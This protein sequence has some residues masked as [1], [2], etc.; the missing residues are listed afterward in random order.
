MVD[1]YC[2]LE[3]ALQ[4]QMA[5]NDRFECELWYFQDLAPPLS[6]FILR[7][8]ERLQERYDNALKRASG[9]EGRLGQRADQFK[10]IATL[11]SA[12]LKAN[13]AFQR[14]QERHQ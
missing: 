12:L 11:K 8:Y 2:S 4:E 14:A 10:K 5:R 6:E 7:R 9:F 3:G 1:S 13:V